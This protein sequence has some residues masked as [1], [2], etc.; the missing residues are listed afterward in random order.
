MTSARTQ[1]EIN[2]IGFGAL[3]AALGREDAIRFIRQFGA[4][5]RQ[6]E[7]IEDPAYLPPMTAEE[8]HERIRDMQDPQD[9]ASML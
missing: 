4:P 9:Q 7:T 2:D 6:E 1:Q 5:A 8:A 3:V